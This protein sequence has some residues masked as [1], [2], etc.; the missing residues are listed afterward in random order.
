MQKKLIVSLLATPMAF[1]A[2]ADIPV[3][4]T[5]DK[6]DV[7]KG[8]P[9]NGYEVKDDGSIEGVVGTATI[10]QKVTP[11]DG[12]PVGTYKI[13]FEA[14]TNVKAV[15]KVGDKEFPL[16][17]T[18]KESSTFALTAAAKEATIV[19]S[20]ADP[21]NPFSFAKAQLVLAL[22]VAEINS[23]V[24]QKLD[25]L[26]ASLDQI[27]NDANQS[28]AAK[29]LR[30]QYTD[31]VAAIAKIG[32][33]N[34]LTD[35]V[36][37]K[38]YQ[39]LN[40]AGWFTTP[41]TDKISEAINAITTGEVKT[42]NDA[43][44]AENNRYA[45]Q[46]QWDALLADL[47][48]D[49]QDVLDAVKTGIETEAAKNGE[50]MAKTLVGY[51]YTAGNEVVTAQ[52]AAQKVIEDYK[53]ALAEAY[54]DLT[55]KPAD[56]KLPAVPTESF[57]AAYTKYDDL[58]G[59]FYADAVAY[60]ITLPE[61]LTG[62]EM[63][64][65]TQYNLAYTNLISVVG[66]NYTEEL[67]A[68]YDYTTALN[69]KAAEWQAAIA[70]ANDEAVENINDA[71]AKGVKGAYTW[72]KEGQ[73][74]TETTAAIPSCESAYDDAIAEFNKINDKE[75]G[76]WNVLMKE[77]NAL[78]DEYVPVLAEMV[79]DFA[80][81][82]SAFKNADAETQAK[83]DAIDAAI[84]ALGNYIDEKY[85][86]LALSE[87]ELADMVSNIND[88]DK[89][90]FDDFKAQAATII[91]LNNDLD[92]VKAWI[93]GYCEDNKLPSIYDK[94][95]VTFQAI[96][97]GIDALPLKPTDAQ[98]KGVK[99]GMDNAKATAKALVD[100]LVK[101]NN[102]IVGTL[103][104]GE[105]VAGLNKIIADD[106]LLFG[107]AVGF[108]D[109]Y[110]ADEKGKYQALIAAINEFRGQYNAALGDKVNP[111]ECF[112]M[113]EALD[114]AIKAYAG[115][116]LNDVLLDYQVKS[117]EANIDAAQSDLDAVTTSIAEFDAAYA[118]AEKSTIFS[119]PNLA[120]VTENA[121]NGIQAE[122]DALT[123]KIPGLS[124]AYD[125]AAEKPNTGF[126][127][128][129]EA[130]GVDKDIKDAAGKVTGVDPCILSQIAALKAEI[131]A[132]KTL[133]SK[134]QGIQDQLGELR[135]FNKNYTI[136]DDAKAHWTGVIDG[137][138]ATI[139]DYIAQ[140]KTILGDKTKSLANSNLLT[141]ITQFGK[142]VNKTDSAIQQNQDEYNTLLEEAQS[143]SSYVNSAIDMVNASTN[144]PE[145]DATKIPGW[146]AQ[147]NAQLNK[148]AEINRNT[149]KYY[150][151]GQFS[152][153]ETEANHGHATHPYVDPQTQTDAYQAVK[154]AVK[155]ILDEVYGADG[156]QALNNGLLDAWNNSGYVDLR[157]QYIASV[158]AYNQYS[159]WYLG[160]VDYCKYINNLDEVKKTHEELY[161]YAAKITELNQVLVDEVTKAN[162]AGIGKAYLV[163]EDWFQENIVEVMNQYQTEM[164][165]LV[166]TMQAA[167]AQGA[168]DYMDAHKGQMNA[169]IAEAQSIMT[170]AGIAPTE[171]TAY[172]KDARTVVTTVE[173]NYATDLANFKK[174]PQDKDYI[175]I[176]KACDNLATQ[177]DGVTD[178]I[179]SGTLKGWNSYYAA[180]KAALG[181]LA[182]AVA[183]YTAIPAT[184]PDLIAFNAAKAVIEGNDN[185]ATDA[186]E[187]LA[188]A[189][190]ILADLPVDC[191]DNALAN[192]GSYLGKLN[193]YFN[194]LNANIEAATNAEAA[195][196]TLNAQLLE[197]AGFPTAVETLEDLYKKMQ[198]FD[199]SLAGDIN[200]NN[201]STI[202]TDIALVKD[203]IAA[204][205]EDLMGNRV[206]ISGL[207]NQAKAA[208][209]SGYDNIVN[210]ENM[211]FF[212]SGGSV[213]TPKEGGI[214]FLI[215]LAYN[216]CRD[217]YDKTTGEPVPGGYFDSEDQAKEV[218]AKI[219]QLKADV[220]ALTESARGQGKPDGT[221]LK[222]PAD[223]V[224]QAQ[225]FEQA[226]CE[227]LAYLQNLVA[228]NND[229]YTTDLSQ[230][231]GAL[232]TVYTE[233]ANAIAAGKAAVDPLVADT[234]DSQYDD[235]LAELNQ[236]QDDITAAGSWILMT[237]ENYE[238]AMK[239][240]L[241]KVEPLN[242]QAKFAADN[243]K[244][245]NRLNESLDF[246]QGTY[247]ELVDKAKGFGVYTD[248]YY[249]KTLLDGI[250]TD[251]ES[252]GDDI[253]DGYKDV[254]HNGLLDSETTIANDITNIA[255]N[256]NWA[257][258]VVADNYLSKSRDAFNTEYS[259][260]WTAL[261][262]DVVDK[263]GFQQ[264][265]EE[266]YDQYHP[267]FFYQQDAEGNWT[268][269]PEITKSFDA[270]NANDKLTYQAK[271]SAQAAVCEEFAARVIALTEQITSLIT[272]INENTYVRG[273]VNGDK[274]VNVADLQTLINWVGEGLTYDDIKAQYGAAI[275]AA[276]DVT[277]TDETLNILD[278]TGLVQ[279]IKGYNVATPNRVAAKKATAMQT[280]AISM[281]SLGEVE[282]GVRRY[283]V[284]LNNEMSLCAAQMDI[285][286]PA[287]C[288]LVNV[289][290]SDRAESHEVAR[291]D[292]AAGARVIIT[293][294]DN[295]DFNGQDG[296]LVFIDVRGTGTPTVGETIFSDSMS[297]GFL[298]DNK[299]LTFID[300]I[301]ET[302][303]EV[304]DTIYNVAGQT[305]RAVQRG[306]NIIR[307]SDGTTSKEIRK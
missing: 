64:L 11:A 167:A 145:I 116:T 184:N 80:S 72:L 107:S 168:Q 190:S 36:T 255:T 98:L 233:V 70:K 159:S 61:M 60:Y 3:A 281:A 163:T 87:T 160:N 222:A 267:M 25:E 33:D 241:A 117:A 110:K 24:A 180:Q 297:N 140:I 202:V 284:L 247:D 283:A 201:A 189:G 236:V 208:I 45:N 228:A 28:D 148:L 8:I 172:L 114:A 245:Y 48:K 137:Y 43:V 95:D 185:T 125:P 141:P 197:V 136:G 205:G 134:L 19:I 210:Q 285:L 262:Q 75:N 243:L 96:Q 118:N 27:D 224:A 128:V 32:T 91:A 131:D 122:I 242:K 249:G 59:G 257:S 26:T 237:A 119:N 227:M 2:M 187:G 165:T 97:E 142:L 258:Y 68:A 216:N 178:K 58:A 244:A 304:K 31:L 46:T 55:K 65:D 150:N 266:I 248:E 229:K 162:T 120:T 235:L 29:A 73:A 207:I 154:D 15:V 51:V 195:L 193:A 54:K 191:D 130:V 63:S 225:K 113:V 173:T 196:R 115:P 157:N 44:A 108:G 84:K 215:N 76:E 151:N 66:V 164:S 135:D 74:A 78:M 183:T 133:V 30:K 37:I 209:G 289:S 81:V 246:V 12:L 39:D 99:D 82:Q 290:L 263:K 270:I 253:E 287:G 132:A 275:A 292:N 217:V 211:A 143:T 221:G 93:K 306:I 161:K 123:A 305:M 264:K 268:I 174:G 254:E 234:Y 9:G 252:V 260:A 294:I 218:N 138:Q 38:Q 89:L 106:T 272:E 83:L 279:I 16:T 153:T 86:Q 21:S 256:L 111:Q 214:F 170:S 40:L 18:G 198:E 182:A 298:A 179:Q 171:A 42:Y 7:D 47:K 213:A 112:D 90:G 14:A 144:D 223:Y 57:N 41:K 158:D 176:V 188:N 79:T 156:I 129:D 53:T 17:V 293:S 50:A 6:W 88:A 271:V 239:A 69:K 181:R 149:G 200:P 194:A 146:L 49:M 22:N 282:D 240:I 94:F 295:A 219:D 278:I 206:T 155:A 67:G 23:E 121:V 296:Q 35:P 269:V 104:E 92:A 192:I 301:Y 250:A 5:T 10:S 56:I 169:L 166:T 212:G 147:L 220:Y 299:G 175:D 307:H 261:R 62:K 276:A 20:S 231:A 52:A 186:I 274:E 177:L 102:Y 251:L 232:T 300:S 34:K 101:A 273:E 230:V 280:V 139:N 288:E 124:A 77:Q 103:G 203:A 105:G 259:N 277:G 1:G 127:A 265:L 85:P 13:V 302:A 199:N 226:A 4:S 303:R 100:E 71:L 109:R 286:L 152:D 204:A 291:F 126:D 238:D